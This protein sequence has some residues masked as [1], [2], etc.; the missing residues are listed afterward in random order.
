VNLK[1]RSKLFLAAFAVGAVSAVAVGILLNS[2]LQRLTVERIEQTLAAETRMAAE[3]LRHSNAPVDELDEEADRLG[4][5]V[6]VRVT[7]IGK[8]GKVLGD[9]SRDGPALAAMENHANRPEIAEASRRHNEVLVRR[10]STTTEYDTLYAAIPITHPTVAFVR[11]SLPLTEIAQQQ[12]A[13][14]VLASSG[15]GT[16]LVIAAL[17]AWLLSAPLASRVTAI[18]EVARRYASGDMTRPSRGYGDDELGEVARALDGA[19]QELGR[20]VNELAHDR[21]H[22]RAILAGMVEGVIVID[23]QGRLVMANGAA[24]AMLKLDDSATGRRY[25]EWMRQSELFAE[26][27]MALRGEAPAGVEFVLARDP[28]RTCVARAAPAG[29]PE[30]GAVLVLHDISDLRRADRVRRDFVANVSHELRTPLTA[31]RGYVEAL[32]DDPPPPED[33]RRFLEII[34]RHTDRME[35]LVKDLLRLARL[36]AGQETTEMVD[37]DLNAIVQAVAHELANIIST[38]GTTVELEIASE[39]RTITSDPAKLHDVLRNLVENA[40]NYSPEHGA[41][42]V[43][44]SRVDGSVILSVLDTGPG[45]PAADLTRVFERFY[46]VDKS[47]SR[48]PGGT[49]IGLAIVKHLVELLG[50]T[51][52]AG[53]RQEGGAAFTVNLPQGSR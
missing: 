10:Y 34:A 30:G 36:D 48:A 27:A 33:Q 50:G 11:L 51:V 17:L 18:A 42:R 25:Q 16:A 23:A 39:V 40:V 13:I 24:R 7:F 45:I 38:K 12:R 43:E 6:G 46:R 8:D 32:I 44:A 29:A 41:V 52:T 15:V 28:S 21:R 9:S 31:I 19:I 20:R 14:L 53:N 26:L 2:R 3:L 4:A 35:R 5:L 22:L 37:C 1:I 47:R 49:G